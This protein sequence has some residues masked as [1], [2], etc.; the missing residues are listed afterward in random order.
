MILTLC[1]PSETLH[2]EISADQFMQLRNPD[3]SAEEIEK[4]AAACGVSGSLL[5]AYAEDL[6]KAAQETIEID[7]S[8][9]Y[10]DHL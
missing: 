10:S 8:C 1:S 5:S 4:I 2:I 3:V 6:K 9:D 7:G